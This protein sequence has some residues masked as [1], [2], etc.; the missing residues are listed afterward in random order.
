MSHIAPVT[1]TGRYDTPP[2]DSRWMVDARCAGLEDAYDDLFSTTAPLTG[3]R[4]A[5]GLCAICPVAEQCLASARTALDTRIAGVRGGIY[6]PYEPS[7]PLTVIPTSANPE[8]GTVAG[9]A[10]HLDGNTEPCVPCAVVEYDATLPVPQPTRYW[11]LPPHG[12][13]ARAREHGRAGE[14]VCPRCVDAVRMAREVRA[15]IAGSKTAAEDVEDIDGWDA[16]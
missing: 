6:F 1:E 9:Y 15:D 13:E 3:R 7:R 2:R 8:C 16:A 12:T 14:V 11:S 5:A 10:A 4:T